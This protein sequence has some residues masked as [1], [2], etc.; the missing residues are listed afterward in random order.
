M[1]V[2]GFALLG[3]V[4]VEADL[5]GRARSV[6]A[7][8][9]FDRVRAGGEFDGAANVV[10][11]VGGGDGVVLVGLQDVA[12]HAALE[13]AGGGEALAVER[14]A[15]VGA[16]GLQVDPVGAGVGRS[17]RAFPGDDGVGRKG[18]AAFDGEVEL[19]VTLRRSAGGSS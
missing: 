4:P 12:V 15:R 3:G 18:I 1:L 9:D 8:G 6:G 2:I 7:G 19:R 14:D 13:C 16:E 10:E 11:A 17:E 5:H